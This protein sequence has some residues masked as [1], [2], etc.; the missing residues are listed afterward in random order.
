MGWILN[1]TAVKAIDGGGGG[2]GGDREGS[3]MGPKEL[4]RSKC[5][6]DIFT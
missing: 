1:N 2:G 5:P 4:I 6:G 3:R